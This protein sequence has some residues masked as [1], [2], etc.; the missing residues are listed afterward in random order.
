V[1]G[2][3]DTVRSI[4]GEAEAIEDKSDREAAARWAMHSEFEP[5]LRAMVSLAE[6]EA[7][8]PVS[9]DE[10][11]ADP[12]L[13]TCLSG[14]VDLR[15]GELRPHRRADLIT[16]IVPL[17]LDRK[18]ECPTWL[19]FLDRVF[20]GDVEL[21]E[22][23]QRAVGY[24]LTGSTQEQVL[25]L[26]HGTGANGKST[27][28][29][30]V[31]ALLGDYAQQADFTTFLHRERESGPRNDLARL[32]GARF[33]AAAEVEDGRRLSEV[34]VKQVT[35]G[36]TITARFL[37]QEHF[38]FKPALKLWLAANHKPTVRGTDNG[39]WRRIRLV[40]FEVT[41]PADEQDKD[42][43]S[44]LQAELPG[45][46]AWAV[47]GCR[48]WHEQGL[49]CPEVVQAATELYKGEMDILGLFL[50][51]SCVLSPQAEIA[52]RAL[53][54]AYTPWCEESGERP[55]SQRNLAR[56]L[57]E[58]GLCAPFKRVGL[59]WWR[60][61]RL[62]SE[63]DTKN[64][65]DRGDGR[66]LSPALVPIFTLPDDFLEPSSTSSPTSPSLVA[67]T[68]PG[69][70]DSGGSPDR[71]GACGDDLIAWAVCEGCGARACSS[72]S[73]CTPGCARMA[74][75]CNSCG[76][77][78]REPTNPRCQRC[79]EI[80]CSECRVC[81]PTCRDSGKVRLDLDGVRV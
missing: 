28:L 10:F 60:G 22:F 67:T 14:T 63:F 62:R 71:C 75:L 43:A 42:L 57:Q 23:I 26:L 76:M 54:D 49:G 44:K 24:S 33:V 15:T 64:D 32:M 37:H 72:C 13:L 45:I 47:R 74:V 16:K 4:Y 2:T 40:P 56:R 29:E 39:I 27:F 36:D 52:S 25:F 6:T 17:Y 73:L 61:I 19:Q 55:M 38:E 41:I 8:I 59:K 58:R 66:D 31:R 34:V 69:G 9:P 81:T 46:F 21:I 12:W 1:S 80:T 65:G 20:R 68:L 3:K 77:F 18:A 11:D 48:Q 70:G 53:Y 78:G 5:R 79:G 7:G 50:D 35:G 51:E 30:I